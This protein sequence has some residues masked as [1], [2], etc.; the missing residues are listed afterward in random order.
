MLFHADM[1]KRYVHHF[2]ETKLNRGQFQILIGEL[3]HK[4]ESWKRSGDTINGEGVGR[5]EA[6]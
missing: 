3:F 6:K 5:Q 4:G 1:V 2:G